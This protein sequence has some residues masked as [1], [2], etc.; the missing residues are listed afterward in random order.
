M[1]VPTKDLV[2]CIFAR[3]NKIQTHQNVIQ[4]Q[5]QNTLAKCI[6]NTTYFRYVFQILVFETLSN[7]GLISVPPV[8]IVSS[9]ARRRRGRINKGANRLL[10]RNEGEGEIENV[11][12]C[13][14]NAVELMVGLESWLGG[15]GGGSRAREW[16]TTRGKIE[17]QRLVG[18]SYSRR[19]FESGRSTETRLTSNAVG[20]FHALPY[21]DCVTLPSKHRN[22]LQYRNL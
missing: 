21:V 11:P 15:G 14:G 3:K 12:A 7:T 9:A 18:S 4:I 8:S 13:G 20:D 6:S 22:H 10:P 19:H 1:L 2:L 17:L 16:S 5:M